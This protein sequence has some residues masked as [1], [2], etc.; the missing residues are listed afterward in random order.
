MTNNRIFGGRAGAAFAM[1]AMMALGGCATVPEGDADAM[2]AYEEANDPLEPLNRYFFEVNYAADEL[3]LKP[4]AG[5]YYTALPNPVQDS[6]RNV[7]RNVST[8]V[9]LANDLFQGDMD[10]AEITFMRFLI[11][12]TF[13]LLGL[14]DVAGEWGYPYHDE[15]FG[16]T[17]AVHGVDEGAYLVLPIFGPSNPRDAFGRG[18]DTL[19]DPL[20]WVLP[21]GWG[22]ARAGIRGIDTRARNLKTL[23]DIRKGSVDYYAAIRSLYRQRR[24]DEIDNG[25]SPDGLAYPGSARL[26]RLEEL[27]DPEELSETGTKTGLQ[28]SSEEPTSESSEV[29]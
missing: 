12:T 2:A 29:N 6:V 22:L 14:F 11:N 1:A 5:W 8:P 19:I 16:Q 28:V 7:L 13:G 20:T 9:V 3:L 26:P 23:D 25:E 18:V 4:F 15:D 27:E 10:R 24:T 21:R 17:L